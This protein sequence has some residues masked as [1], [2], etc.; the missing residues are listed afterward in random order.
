MKRKRIGE[1]LVEVGLITREQL[2][3]A[4]LLQQSGKN[5]RLGEILVEKGFITDQQLLETLEFVLGIPRIELSKIKI[6]SEAI[7]L[8]PAS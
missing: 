6:D 1:M 2:D 3:E 7:N 8:L 4:V 5:Q